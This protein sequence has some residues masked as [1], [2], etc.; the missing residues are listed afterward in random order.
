[1]RRRKTMEYISIKQ[2]AMKFNV[3]DR[4]IR[5]LCL[6]DAIPGAAKLGNSW[7]VPADF[8]I[9][10]NKLINI[11]VGGAHSEGLEISLYLLERGEQVCIIDNRKDAVL[12]AIE[13]I[14]TNMKKCFIYNVD[15]SDEKELD[16]ICKDLHSYQISKLFL[17]DYDVYFD[18]AENTTKESIMKHFRAPVYGSILAVAKFYPMMKSTTIVTLLRT[19]ASTVG[20]ANETIF[21]AASH[22]L[23]GYMESLKKA[24]EAEEKDINVLRVY[25][26]ATNN[27]FW[28][29]ENSKNVFVKPS[30][31]RI[32]IDTLAKLIVDTANSQNGQFVSKIFVERL[33]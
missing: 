26:G 31:N 11:I 32:P 22:G 13:K 12:D 1:M 27:E 18:K 2:A 33:K 8:E 23:D 20:L 25:T 9:N 28:L 5:K 21:N 24:C 10:Q 3:S 16:K 17:A 29:T 30:K 19:K 7:I 15:V 6:Q 14:G 4:Y